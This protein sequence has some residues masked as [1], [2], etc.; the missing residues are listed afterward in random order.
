MRNKFLSLS[1]SWF[2]V[3]LIS[4]L[5]ILIFLLQWWHV[6]LISPDI[7]ETGGSN[8]V[9]AIT[10]ISGSV[11]TGIG[12]IATNNYANRSLEYFYFFPAKF[13]E[14]PQRAHPVLIIV[15]GLSGR[16]SNAANSTFRE[17]ALANGWIIL[18]PSFIFDQSNWETA[19]SYQFP[20]VW[21]GQA[22]L[23]IMKDFSS[24]QHLTL[25][26]IFLH[27]V[28]AGAQFVVRFA[29][30][31]PGLCQAVSAYAGGGTIIPEKFVP[32]KF[33]ISIGRFD[34][35]RMPQFTG[36]LEKAFKL[37]IAVESRIYKSGHR[38]LPEQIQDSIRFFE[39]S[40]L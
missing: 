2:T 17:A 28:S 36:F 24:R 15:P 13:I 40:K 39:K 10:S 16:G 1:L 26:R 35:S 25:G 19:T 20:A 11:K 3:L 33:F 34:T 4:L 18:A 37:G 32:V 5:L 31:R 29:L 22:L 7:S 23:D 9:A 27:G 30:W 21:S 14:L 6:K 12:S 38:L 8:P